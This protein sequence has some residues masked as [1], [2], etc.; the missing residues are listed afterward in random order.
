MTDKEKIEYLKKLT[1]VKPMNPFIAIVI[2]CLLFLI[3]VIIMGVGLGFLA[4]IV[5]F[6]WGII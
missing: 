4:V 3:G 6:F 1:N 5:K 2:I